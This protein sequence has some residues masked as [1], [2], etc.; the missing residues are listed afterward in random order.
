MRPLCCHILKVE[1]RCRP[2]ARDFS[3]VIL[4][5]LALTFGGAP[6]DSPTAPCSSV[7][8]LRP[9]LVEFVG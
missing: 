7:C 6:L 8:F 5:R 2:W 3:R 4:M 9:K 1:S